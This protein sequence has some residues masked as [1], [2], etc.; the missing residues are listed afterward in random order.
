M[1][2]LHSL[3]TYGLSVRSRPIA[4]VRP[5]DRLRFEA[6]RKSTRLNSSHANISY[7]VFCLKKTSA[8]QENDL[9]IHVDYL[10]GGAA[11]LRPRQGREHRHADDL[12]LETAGCDLGQHGR[13]VKLVALAD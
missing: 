13:E 5:R 7:A 12:L 3:Q 2:A 6:D 11:D 8:A 4:N 1:S 10:D 9:R